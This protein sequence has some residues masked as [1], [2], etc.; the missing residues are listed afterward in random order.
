MY[1]SYLYTGQRQPMG[2]TWQSLFVPPGSYANLGEGKVLWNAVPDSNQLP[3]SAR[4]RKVIAF[5]SSEWYPED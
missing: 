4:D 1:S 2:Q 3:P 5:G